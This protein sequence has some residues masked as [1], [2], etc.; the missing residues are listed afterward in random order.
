MTSQKKDIVCEILEAE[1]LSLKFKFDAKFKG[2]ISYKLK[3]FPLKFKK[4]KFKML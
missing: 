3:K 2:K 1:K 4:L